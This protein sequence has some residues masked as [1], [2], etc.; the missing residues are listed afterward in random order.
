M[1]SDLRIFSSESASGN[2]TLVW[3]VQVSLAVTLIGCEVTGKVVLISFEVWVSFC[4]SVGGVKMHSWLL[5]LENVTSIHSESC[6]LGNN[7]ITVCQAVIVVS[8]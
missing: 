5:A 2:I 7:G 8:S 3:V 1:V 4:R 6:A